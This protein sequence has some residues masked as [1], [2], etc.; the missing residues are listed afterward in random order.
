MLNN[1]LVWSIHYS[2][3]YDTKNLKFLVVLLKIYEKKQ[4]SVTTNVHS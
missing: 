3:G 2:K 1:F 4:F